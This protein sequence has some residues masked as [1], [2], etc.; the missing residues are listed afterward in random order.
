MIGDRRDLTV[1]GQLALYRTVQEAL[2]NTARHAGPGAV[3][4]VEFDWERPD[5]VAVVVEDEVPGA[6]DPGAGDALFGD[7]DHVEG[8]G[9][10]VVRERLE[11]LGGALEV[12]QMEDGYRVRG[13]VPRDAQ[14][15]PG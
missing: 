11:S 8:R 14:L 9:L 1:A 7:A 6:T 4:H 5:S 15:L 3:A 13:V 2:T 12:E 10:R